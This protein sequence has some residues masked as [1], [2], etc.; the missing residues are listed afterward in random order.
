MT[1]NNSIRVKP[2]RARRDRPGSLGA[3]FLRHS[4]AFQESITFAITNGESLMVTMD[5]RTRIGR[6]FSRH[7]CGNG[8]RRVSDMLVILEPHASKPKR[9]KRQ[10]HSK[11][12]AIS[13]CVRT[14]RQRRGVRL[15]FCRS[16][17]QIGVILPRVLT[18]HRIEAK[19]PEKTGA[20]QKLR[21]PSAS[22]SILPGNYRRTILICDIDAPR[23]PNRCHSW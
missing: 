7:R 15:S 2:L 8:S 18:C 21:P 11:S 5:K 1:T 22:F 19:A 9:Q 10:A 16:W 6:R 4:L 20:L 23:D 13:W 17:L 3:E 12:F 14:S